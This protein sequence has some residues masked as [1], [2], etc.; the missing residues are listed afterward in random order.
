M[1]PAGIGFVR[2]DGGARR[3]SCRDQVRLKGKRGER[4]S[5]SPAPSANTVTS[6]SDAVASG[7]G[8]FAAAVMYEESSYMYYM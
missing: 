1:V 6:D 2:S 3:W 5:R 8:F 7:E 4:N